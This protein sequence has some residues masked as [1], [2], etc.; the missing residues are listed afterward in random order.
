MTLTLQQIRPALMLVVVLTAFGFIQFALYFMDTSLE[1]RHRLRTPITI[2]TAVS[3]NHLCSLEAF[4][5]D[6]DRVFD[7]FGSST[8]LSGTRTSVDQAKEVQRRER[9][10]LKKLK[11][12]EERVK[13]CQRYIETSP[14]LAI[15]RKNDE[16]LETNITASIETRV[17]RTGKA[18]SKSKLPSRKDDKSAKV[19][20][21]D[22]DTAADEED[23]TTNVNLEVIQS[24]EDEDNDE[25]EEEDEPDESEGEVTEEEDQEMATQGPLDRTTT[26]EIQPGSKSKDMHKGGLNT[27]DGVEDDNDEVWPRLIVYNL[28]MGNNKKKLR[29]FQALIEAGY[30]DEIH[31][32]DFDRRP[33]FWRLGTETRGQYGWKAGIMEEV[34]QRILVSQSNN[35]PPAGSQ[36]TRI[37]KSK[38]LPSDLTDDTPQT[39]K[40]QPQLRKQEDHESNQSQAAHTPSHILLWLDSGDRISLPFLR[41]L[42]FSSSLRQLGVWTPQSQDDFQNWTHTGLLEYYHDSMEK[43]VQGETNCNGAVIAWDLDNNNHH[44]DKN[45]ILQDWIACA[46]DESCI[47]PQGSSRANHRQDQS[48]LTYLIKKQFN[49]TSPQSP[50]D[51][52]R[53]R[54]CF[55]MPVEFG[56]LVNQDR[57]CKEAIARNQNHVISD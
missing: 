30:I 28:G 26:A 57:Y 20:K 15:L 49:S 8:G 19:K 50:T 24:G 2:I 36:K 23:H 10:K 27:G 52:G 53:D 32:F 56:V 29:R 34:S 41:W 6:L 54:I 21:E 7:R 48:A 40:E 25:M 13:N 14:D 18:K 3:E 37:G 39:Q 9:E 31:D 1:A 38:V 43:F 51:R 4:L 11:R 46:K 35:H 17:A 55:G 42:P 44:H 12:K 47:A 22:R 33:A 5:Y 16:A 45:G